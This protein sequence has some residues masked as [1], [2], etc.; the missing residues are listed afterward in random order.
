VTAPILK[1]TKANEILEHPFKNANHG[2]SPRQIEALE[3]ALRGLPTPMM[4]AEMNLPE[5]T[6]KAHM[7]RALG[8][9]GISKA[10]LGWWVLDRLRETLG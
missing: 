3:W 4:A 2:L 5:G 8:K 1:V 10:E 9:L 7:F 6:V